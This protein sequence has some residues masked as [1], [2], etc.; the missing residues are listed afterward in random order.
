MKR[1]FTICLFLG[2]PLMAWAAGGLS[3]TVKAPTLANGKTAKAFVTVLGTASR[4]PFKK[5]VA[6]NEDG[7]FSVQNVP[8]GEY[9]LYTYAEGAVPEYYDDAKDLRDAKKVAVNDNTVTEGLT[10]ELAAIVPPPAP[11]KGTITGFV[12]DAA[13]AP[14]A[15]ALVYLIGRQTQNRI[16]TDAAGAY[17]F[18][19]L[20][21]DYL[22]Y[23]AA[24]GFLPQYYQNAPNPQSATNVTVTK[25]QTTADVNFVLAKGGVISGKVTDDAGVAQKDVRVEVYSAVAKSGAVT[26]ETGAYTVSGLPASAYTVVANTKYGRLFYDNATTE[27]DAKAVD[28]TAG[29]TVADINFVVKS[30]AYGAVSGKVTDGSGNP[31][32]SREAFVVLQPSDPSTRPLTRYFSAR[33]D[34][35]GQYKFDKVTTGKYYVGLQIADRFEQTMIWYDNTT[36]VTSAKAVEVKANETTADINFTVAEPKGVVSGTVKDAQGNPVE[37]AQ[38]TLV[39]KNRKMQAATDATGAFSFTKLPDAT[40]YVNVYGCAGNQCKSVWYENATNEKDAKPVVVT[41]GAADIASVDVVLPIEKGTSSLSGAVKDASGAALAG[42]KVVAYFKTDKARVFAGKATTDDAGTYTI[43]N[44]RAGDYIVWAGYGTEETFGEAWFDGAAKADDAT[45]VTLET[46]ANKSNVNFALTVNPI[47]GSVTGTVVD[48]S[49]NG[50]RAYVALQPAKR[51]ADPGK[52]SVYRSLVSDGKFTFDKVAAGDYI[53]SAYTENGLAYSGDTQDKA[54]A[55][56]FTVVAGAP[57]EV[58]LHVPALA[59]GTN[60]IAGKVEPDSLGTMEAAFVVATDKTQKLKFATLTKADGTY[61]IAGLPDGSYIVMAAAKG[62]FPMYYNQVWNVRKATPVTLSATQATAEG[63]SFVLT[64]IKANGKREN[65]LSVD[66]SG[67]A[68]MTVLSGRVSDMKNTPVIGAYV[69]ALDNT[70]TPVDY[71]ETDDAGTYAIVDLPAG[72]TYKLYVSKVGYDGANTAD[73]IS[74]S[75][76]VM[77][78]QG[79]VQQDL[80]LSPDAITAVEGEDIIPTTIELQGNYPNPFNPSTNIRFA[81]PEAGQV[82]ITVYDLTGRLLTQLYQGVLPAGTNTIQWNASSMPSGLYLYRI[83]TA[84][85]FATGKMMLV[86]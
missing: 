5:N 25:D 79:Q 10:I 4:N 28:V 86:K 19:V 34:S 85:A 84:N 55:V 60:S 15:K 6:V 50:L 65:S 49:G 18:T 76:D 1:L 69:Y 42:A 24:D 44:L 74:A 16:E 46:G 64:T 59:L 2:L 9:Y 53:L 51:I 66:M 61:S 14:I 11:A 68:G 54:A 63:I 71:S 56:P 23:A 12:H 57:T 22:L 8:A 82:R 77:V 3:G 73:A 47:Y 27:Q 78:N 31:F 62:F 40:Y 35:L 29:A 52:V 83:Q 75:N 43:A 72:S 21:G 58:T 7:S 48:A 41:A 13:G 39:G 67:S 30:P 20:T 32:T 38:V 33:V 36:D 26:D 81:L 17:S 80:I 45:V 70:G 37:R